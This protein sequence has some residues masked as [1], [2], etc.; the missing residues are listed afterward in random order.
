MPTSGTWNLQADLTLSANGKYYHYDYSTGYFGLGT[1][2][3]DYMVDI[4]HATRADIRCYDTTNDV[5]VALI[6]ESGTAYVGSTTSDDLKIM[7]GGS[8]KATLT[9]DGDFGVGTSSPDARCEISDTSNTELRITNTGATDHSARIQQTDSGT[10]IGGYDST[11]TI[12][13]AFRAYGDSYLLGGYYGVG[14]DNPQY[15]IHAYDTGSSTRPYVM[16]ETSST[17]S[18]AGYQIKTP[19][20]AGVVYMAGTDGVIRLRA[21][22]Y[23]LCEENLSVAGTVY[24]DDYRASS[25]TSVGASATTIAISI[26]LC[27]VRGADGGGNN[28]TDLI[29]TAE[30]GSS[31]NVVATDTQGSPAARSYTVS[32]NSLRL[33]MS[34]GTYTIHAVN[35]R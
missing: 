8:V 11:N 33:A 10:W 7:V 17:G 24:A 27:M 4:H 19:G 13:M 34:S 3:P 6:A 20:G 30:D 18:Y 28:F 21:D 2:S 15:K 16:S 5:G 31:P 26:G 14:T 22:D 32:S 1:S 9:T 29:I 23:I 12:K 25:N 35:V